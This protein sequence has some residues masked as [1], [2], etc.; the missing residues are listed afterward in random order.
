MHTSVPAMILVVITLL[1]A[2]GCAGGTPT[3]SGTRTTAPAPSQILPM[4]VTRTGG[5]IGV[6]DRVTVGVDGSV[7]VARDGVPGTPATM[8]A[9]EFTQLKRLLAQAA[10]QTSTP[11]GPG[12][13]CS[14]GFRYRVRTPTLMAT[15]D[16]CS[17]DQQPTIH[18]ILQIAS[19]LL[20]G[21]AVPASRSTG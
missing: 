17:R 16:D 19:E 4:E 2:A 1:G 9:D 21:A 12:T 18:R 6:D 11:T 7:I 3:S 10:A 13:V 20:H 15:V 8:D 5:L 14:D